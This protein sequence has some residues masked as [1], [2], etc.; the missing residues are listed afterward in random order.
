[1]ENLRICSFSRVS[2]SRPGQGTNTINKRNQVLCTV[3][4]PWASQAAPRS[5]TETS[6]TLPR[7]LTCPQRQYA[8]RPDVLSSQTKINW[9]VRHGSPAARQPMD[10]MQA[11]ST[12]RVCS[13]SRLTR[14][15]G[16]LEHR[17]RSGLLSSSPGS[18]P[19]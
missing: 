16:A 4:H 9:F 19:C 3:R 18:A 10:F 13:S 2:K 17:L 8:E 5:Y 1:M 6:T 11:N 14:C 7:L 12:V 15:C